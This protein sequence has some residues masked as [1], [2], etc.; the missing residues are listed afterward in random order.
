MTIIQTVNFDRT[1]VK[2][3]D[4]NLQISVAHNTKDGDEISRTE[5]SEK[6]HPD[7]H[8]TLLNGNENITVNGQSHILT[9]GKL[10]AFWEWDSEPITESDL[11][12]LT[13]YLNSVSETVQIFRDFDNKKYKATFEYAGDNPDWNPITFKYGL[14]CGKAGFTLD[15]DNSVL[16][17]IERKNNIT[18]WEI[19]QIDLSVGQVFD[20]E[21]I[22]D[23]ICYTLFSQTVD[24]GGTTIPK[25]SCR[26]QTSA[27]IQITNTSDKPCKIIQVYR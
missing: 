22:G 23:N 20:A 13:A 1:Y 14:K 7:L 3:F 8:D 12:E 15:T 2:L 6:A 5:L 27:S 19:R 10:S 9:E 16:F 4:D 25:Y 17:C 24:V 21:K 11:D 26:N 18:D